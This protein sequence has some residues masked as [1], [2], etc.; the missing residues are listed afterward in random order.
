[1]LESDWMVLDLSARMAVKINPDHNIQGARQPVYMHI[2]ATKP[3][4]F[5]GRPR[6]PRVVR[7]L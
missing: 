1:M 6:S 3:H 5:N 4:S 7:Q 2:G